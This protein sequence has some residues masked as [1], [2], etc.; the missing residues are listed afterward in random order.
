MTIKDVNWQ[1]LGDLLAIVVTVLLASVIVA[2]AG[3]GDQTGPLP[4]PQPVRIELKRPKL[5]HPI[6]QPGEISQDGAAGEALQK[7]VAEH[8]C[9]AEAMYYEARG[10]GETG[11]RAVA[12]VVL[13]RL[14]EG[15]HGHTI[16]SVVYE[17]VGQ[18]F[19]Q[20]TFACDGS[21]S[22]PKAGE[23]WRAA[24]VLAARLLA[25]EAPA[26]GAQGAT[27]YHTISVHPVWEPKLV[28]VAQIGNHV[29]F[30]PRVEAFSVGFRGSMQ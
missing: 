20:F 21:L 4:N 29:F 15:L 17:G 18:T 24:E 14:T 12:E 19:C 27:Y 26:N 3:D 30:R 9:L 16:C 5:S 25:G 7:L 6:P 1:K 28:R 10:E 8:R 2:L 22:R 13:N 11:E 23:P